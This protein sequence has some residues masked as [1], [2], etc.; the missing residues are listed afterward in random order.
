MTK[1]KRHPCAI[2]LDKFFAEVGDRLSDPVT[3]GG[4][5]GATQYLRNRLMTAFRA[6]WDAGYSNATG[7]KPRKARRSTAGQVTR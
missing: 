4:A 2:A 6:G 5:P 7:H 1:A 3:L